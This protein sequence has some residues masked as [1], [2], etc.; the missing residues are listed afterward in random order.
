VSLVSRVLLVLVVSLLSL[1]SLCLVLALARPAPARAAASPP[2]IDARAAA[3]LSADTGQLLW[4]RNASAEVAIASTTKLMT[5]LLT[6]EHARLTAV[7]TEPR[8]YSSPADSQI[9]LVPGERMTVHDL[10]IALLLPSADDA[11]EDLAFNVGGGSVA[12]FIV[13]M[14]T[15]ARTLGLTHTHYT[16]PIGLDTPGNYSSATD[17]ARLARYVLAHE[18]FFR[19]VVALPRATLRTGAFHR[20]VIN[21]NDLVASVPWMT[22]VKTG[23]T[24]Q[25]GYV[26]VGSGTRH[27]TSLISVVLGTP[28]EAE[29]DAS[30]LSLLRWGFSTFRL[31]EPVRAGTVMARARVRGRPGLHPALRAA[32][33][34]R[35][36]IG[37]HARVVIRVLAPR[38]IVGPLRRGAQVGSVRVLAGGRLIARVPLVLGAAVPAP[39]PPAL[40]GAAVPVTL[41]FALLLLLAA[42]GV[43]EFYRRRGKGPATKARR[44]R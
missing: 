18:P 21:R 44:R 20:T 37:A 11:A 19:H 13:M 27:A 26:L 36:V 22:G 43:L 35:R 39:P 8:Y 2:R 1:V 15:R 3:L 24:A 4:G 14:N 42:G 10:L 5:A 40:A 28:S 38:T 32:G 6:L 23:H 29:R 30:T 7:F 25:A 41:L 33:A 17:L 9:G 16:T 12:R 34:V 31:A